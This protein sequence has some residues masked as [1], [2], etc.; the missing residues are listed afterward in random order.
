MRFFQ[1]KWR[2]QEAITTPDEVPV[3]EAK[4]P[5]NIT[6]ITSSLTKVVKKEGPPTRKEEKKR[7]KLVK[8]EFEKRK[9]DRAD[10]IQALLDKSREHRYGM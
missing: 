6:D 7:K 4:P 10:R 9:E 3:V 1:K 5:S 8:K 2:V